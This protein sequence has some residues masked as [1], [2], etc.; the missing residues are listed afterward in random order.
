MTELQSTLLE[1]LTVTNNVL[2]IHNIKPFLVGGS[3]IGALRHKGFIPWDDDIDVALL[4]D[5]YEKAREILLKELPKGYFFVD[6]RIDLNYPYEFGKVKKDHTSFVHEGDAHLD[7][8]HGIYIDIFPID[9][10]PDND[11]DLQQLIRKVDLYKN[12]YCWNLMSYKK[13]N[14]LRPVWQWFPIAFAHLFSTRFLVSKLENLF[15]RYNNTHTKRVMFFGGGNW[16]KAI[17]KREYLSEVKC[18][19]F[20]DT[21]AFIPVGYH[22]YLHQIFG[23]YMQLPPEDQRRSF[24]QPYYISFT[25][26][27]KPGK[28]IAK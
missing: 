16:K 10:C 1:I 28:T 19:E 4:R 17:Y 7:I 12:L 27:Y 13:G 9:N 3:C 15:S 23:D 18:V 8:H 24:H 2:S 22:E 6:N 26:N 25:D 11:I 21:T 5:D 14:N 20:E